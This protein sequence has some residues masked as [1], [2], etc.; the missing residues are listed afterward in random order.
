M[1]HR[2]LHLVLAAS[3][4]SFAF[5]FAFGAPIAQAAPP[6]CSV[7]DVQSTILFSSVQAAQDAA[8]PGDK[9]VVKG[10]CIENI[11]FDRNLLV[12]GKNASGFGLPT[13][14]GNS[15]GTTVTV[16]AGVVLTIQG[17]TITGGSGTI[18]SPFGFTD[19]YGGGV[20]NDG[21]LTLKSVVVSGNSS[22]NGGGI[23]ND[24]GTLTLSN[25]SVKNNTSGYTGGG[26]GSYPTAGNITLNHS[27]V[28]NN[29]AFYGAGMILWGGT[30]SLKYSSVSNNSGTYGGGAYV[31]DATNLTLN[32][33]TVSGNGASL[34]AGLFFDTSTLTMKN[35]S[36]I[37]GNTASSDGGGIW[38]NGANTFN[39]VIVGTN[40]FGNN[41]DDFAP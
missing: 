26:I 8:N 30:V 2:S 16:N 40:V 3:L 19:N 5:A 17:L 4:V 33:S 10:T 12:A 38:D 24:G 22:N 34:G 21:S 27:S 37:S 32:G 35:G 18:A 23:F 41:P 36:T 14:N 20:F 9:L 15:T 1:N 13:L 29:T 25:S 7:K 6:P 28:S 31:G 11:S 39:A